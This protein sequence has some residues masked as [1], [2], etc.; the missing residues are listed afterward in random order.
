MI[1]AALLTMLSGTACAPHAAPAPDVVYAAGHVNDTADVLSPAVRSELE[2]LLARHAA[3]TSN[4][5]AVLTIPTLAGEAP[6]EYALR[7]ATAWKLGQAGKD[8]GVLLLIAR[9]DREIRIEVGYGLEGD[10]ADALCARIIR[11][12]IVPRFR[13]G[14]FDG[15]T[16]AGVRAIIKAI[17]GAYR[18]DESA[19]ENGN[20][21]RKAPR[22]FGVPLLIDNPLPPVFYY[23]MLAFFG[24]VALLFSF[25]AAFSRPWFMPLFVLPCFP[26]FGIFY[27]TGAGMALVCLA[28]LAIVYTLRYMLH[29]SRLGRRIFDWLSERGG[30]EHRLST[31]PGF[32]ASA[33]GNSSGGFSNGLPNVP[34]TGGGISGGGEF[35]GGGASGRW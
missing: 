17:D 33:T 1:L 20:R 11:R 13:D 15:G 29:R 5:I 18:A 35:G 25:S 2:T 27:L 30:Y 28:Y 24:A 3:R 6:D 12:E 26:I 16:L 8:N 31:S 23:G 14:D 21:A 7:V 34:A 32:K 19:N 4:Q 9:D 10:L 22:F